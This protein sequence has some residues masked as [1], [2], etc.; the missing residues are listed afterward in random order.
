M[1]TRARVATDF[2][3]DLGAEERVERLAGVRA[4]H[5]S[6]TA[7]GNVRPIA[8]AIWASLARPVGL[9][10]DPRDEEVLERRRE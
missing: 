6:S 1:C 3:D 8:A 9:S 7:T 10:V 5:P 2:A 4:A